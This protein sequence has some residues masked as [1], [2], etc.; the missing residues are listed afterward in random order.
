MDPKEDKEL[1]LFTFK[2]DVITYLMIMTDS[3]LCMIMN[4]L[5]SF[6]KKMESFVTLKPLFIVVQIDILQ[7]QF[8]FSETLKLCSVP[9]IVFLA[10]CFQNSVSS[11]KQVFLDFVDTDFPPCDLSLSSESIL[12]GS[13]SAFYL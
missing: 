1:A 11:I 6:C 7:C 3:C 8:I 9:L 5:F 2:A 13:F 4:R 10:L 12:Y